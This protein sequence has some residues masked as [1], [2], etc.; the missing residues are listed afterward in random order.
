M[1]I[2]PVPAIR[3]ALKRAGLSL[4]DMSSVEINEAFGVQYLACEKELGL[5]RSITNVNGGAISLG[6]W[7]KEKKIIFV[8]SN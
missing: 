7:K 4:K 8:S 2:G 6:N 5:D 3:T 1:G